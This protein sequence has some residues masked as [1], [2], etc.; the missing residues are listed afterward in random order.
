MRFAWTPGGTPLAKLEL[1]NSVV[2]AASIG[3]GLPWPGR[4]SFAKVLACFEVLRY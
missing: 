3:V 4:G 2:R 1:A